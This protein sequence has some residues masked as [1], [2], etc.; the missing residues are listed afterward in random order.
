MQTHEIK[1]LLKRAGIDTKQVRVNQVR[2]SIFVRILD[3]SIPREQVESTLK[4]L[5]TVRNISHDMDSIYVGISVRVLYQSTP[6]D[7][8]KV[9]ITQRLSSI[10]GFSRSNFDSVQRAALTLQSEAPE[11]FRHLSKYDW[12]DLINRIT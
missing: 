10:D 9:Y 2:S 1:S 6:A 12:C 11:K 4:H 3:Y 8:L 7:E 5:H